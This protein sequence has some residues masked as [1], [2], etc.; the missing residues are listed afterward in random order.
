MNLKSVP[1]GAQMLTKSTATRP[2]KERFVGSIGDGTALRGTA[3]ERERYGVPLASRDAQA[4]AAAT[5]ARPSFSSMS[6]L[7]DGRLP[8]RSRCLP[9]S[10]CS[11]MTPFSPSPAASTNAPSTVDNRFVHSLA[12]PGQFDSSL[13]R[14]AVPGRP[15]VAVRPLFGAVVPCWRTRMVSTMGDPK[16]RAR[17]RAEGGGE[18]PLRVVEGPL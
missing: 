16:V 18:P 3:A 11:K 14:R 10:P 2:V 17:R 6:G 7:A 13:P 4:V 9:G 15:A 1:T 5:T 12:G 8:H